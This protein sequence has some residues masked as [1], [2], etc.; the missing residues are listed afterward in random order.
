MKESRWWVGSIEPSPVVHLILN[1]NEFPKASCGQGE[2]TVKWR[3]MPSV[4]LASGHLCQK[5]KKIYESL[6]ALAEGREL[7]LSES[8]ESM[9][10]KESAIGVVTFEERIAQLDAAIAKQKS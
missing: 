2:L 10:A 9:K 5:C 8:I 6:K 1:L 7:V 4:T 3:E